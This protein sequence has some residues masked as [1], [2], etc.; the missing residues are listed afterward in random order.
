MAHNISASELVS[1]MGSIIKYLERLT[2]STTYPLAFLPSFT[3]KCVYE[4][5]YHHESFPNNVSFTSQ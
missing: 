4:S 5:G 3:N 1:H 2:I